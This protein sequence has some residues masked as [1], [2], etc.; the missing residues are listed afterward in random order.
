V[1][2]SS[3]CASS[4][5]LPPTCTYVATSL[6]HKTNMCFVQKFARKLTAKIKNS[7]Q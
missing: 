6:G 4:T 7:T 3:Q 1:F 2:V 5:V